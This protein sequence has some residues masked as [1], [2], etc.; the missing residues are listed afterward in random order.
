MTVVISGGSGTISYQWQSSSDGSTGWANALG[1]GSTTATFTPPSTVA[2]TTYYRV[3]VTDLANGCSDP[4]SNALSV[5]V[6]GQPTVEISAD[7]NII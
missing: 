1:T 2:G 5:T 4:V 3:L 6:D 7:N